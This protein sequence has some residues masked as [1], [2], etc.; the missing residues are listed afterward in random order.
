M[1]LHE[2]TMRLHDNY[3][4]S[5]LQPRLQLKVGAMGM[6]FNFSP[7][8]SKSRHAQITRIMTI[9]PFHD[10]VI[11]QFLSKVSVQLNKFIFML[12]VL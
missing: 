2:I 6:I 5:H 8:L 10:S 7:N 9:G 4:Y 12:E 11:S 3:S 1:R